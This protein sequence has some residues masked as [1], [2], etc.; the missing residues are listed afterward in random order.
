MNN[1]GLTPGGSWGD[2]YFSERERE[3]AHYGKRSKER[4]LKFRDE[5]DRQEYLNSI[6]RY[7]KERKK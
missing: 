4:D 5:Q 3:E 6:E 2:Y 1:Y 7:S